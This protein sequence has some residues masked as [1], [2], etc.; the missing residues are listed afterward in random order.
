MTPEADVRTWIDNFVIGLG[1]CPFARAA[2]PGL[3]VVTVGAGSSILGAILDEAA[4]LDTSGGPATTL[5]IVAA[6]LESFDDYL[7]AL[8][9]AEGALSAAGYDGI[10]QLASFHPGYVFEG[11][12]ADDPANATNRSPWPLFHLLRE[13]DV[14]AAIDAHPDAESI[15]VRNQ[16]LL[17][18]Y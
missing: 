10:V 4:A 8:A 16:R 7:D 1:L 17:R 13:A 15:P 11:A 18:G 5:V 9:Q 6:G 14:S 2:L 12:P 3:R